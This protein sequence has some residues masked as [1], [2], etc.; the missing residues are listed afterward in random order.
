MA[1]EFNVQVLATLRDR[2]SSGLRLMSAG[3]VRTEQRADLLRRRLHELQI[4]QG[5]MNRRAMLSTKTDE[6]VISLLGQRHAKLLAVSD[7][8]ATAARRAALNAQIRERSER[9]SIRRA[10][11]QLRLTR[12]LNQQ[13][14]IR[15]QIEQEAALSSARAGMVRGGLALGGGLVGLDLA[16]H[17]AKAAG[18]LQLRE[19]TMQAVY[20][21]SGS[22]MARIRTQAFGLSRT[23]GNLSAG[24]VEQLRL[25]LLGAGLSR[26]ATGAVL[27][28]VAR[29]VDVL[30][31]VRGMPVQATAAQMAQIANLFGARSASRFRP[32]GESL[33]HAGLIAPGS[34]SEL[35]TQSSYIGPLM[36]RGFNAQSIIRL[37]VLS[38]QLGGR[39]A[40]SPENLATFLARLQI[41]KTQQGMALALGGRSLIAARWLGLPG[42][43]RQHPNYDLADLQHLLMHDR[44]RLGTT[45]FLTYA[46]MMWGA[47]GLRTA[48]QLSQ[49]QIATMLSTVA[50]RMQAMGS[51]SQMNAA[52][53][54]TLPRQITL[55]RTN[56]RSLVQ[57]TGA[58]LVAPLQAL[59][60]TLAMTTGNLTGFF[61][62]H[63]G[64]SALVGRTEAT[65]AAFA[66]IGG[67]ASLL[68]STLRYAAARGFL[69]N[70]SKFASGLDLISGALG[71]LF[72][73]VTMAQA[74][75]TLAHH[76]NRK[77]ALANPQVG[78]FGGMPAWERQDEAYARA[79]PW[80]P[81]VVHHHHVT[82]HNHI[83][84][85]SDERMKK[86]ARSL[87]TGVN[88]HTRA[89]GTTGAPVHPRS[90][91]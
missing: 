36:R 13:V 21:Y 2:V 53:L 3:F 30:N 5:L 19:R 39:G 47:S 4:T 51:S 66:A 64:A 37:A 43:I 46:Q 61:A 89:H 33:L 79:H 85:D 72:L 1:S 44:E 10:S 58:P 71:R 60:H 91:F 59:N 54:D 78:G 45:R 27:P 42:F 52:L 84:V 77:T 70:A 55:L 86:L 74:S 15:A 73:P 32:I 87:K 56:L 35:L 23:L 57:A 49:P 12:Q 31:A 26:R 29:T 34:L 69:V 7:L 17:G 20:G 9:A 16:V 80:S 40:V 8:E 48:E 28:E 18:S 62:H 90:V 63:K 83:A 6:R 11:E 25:S 67:G 88:T 41:T 68:A 65:A 14:A 82:N 75:W 81:A 22:Q 76:L 50:R 24:D 38:Q